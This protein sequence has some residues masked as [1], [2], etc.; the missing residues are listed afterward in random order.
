MANANFLI[1]WPNFASNQVTL[2]LSH[3]DN[4]GAEVMPHVSSTNP[5]S[6][7]SALYTLV[8]ELTTNSTD[9]EYS[10][11]TYLRPLDFGAGLS[12]SSFVPLSQEKT[13]FIYASCSVHPGSSSENAILTQHDQVHLAR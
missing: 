6:S 3:P 13:N 11:V 10:V 1:A 2:T 7:T 12:T 5:A 8:D 9:S 4:G